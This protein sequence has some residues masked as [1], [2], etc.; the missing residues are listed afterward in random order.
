MPVVVGVRSSCWLGSSAE[1]GRDGLWHSGGG[2]DDDEEEE[3][4]LVAS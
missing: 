3:E 1:E 2:D 4:A